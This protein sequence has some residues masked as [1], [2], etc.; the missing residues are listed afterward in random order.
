M[1][2][3]SSSASPQREACTSRVRS[4][5]VASAAPT[6]HTRRSGAGTSTSCAATRDAGILRVGRYAPARLARF[7]H[8]AGG[9]A[10]AVRTDPCAPE[11]N[12]EEATMSETDSRAC[13]RRHPGDVDRSGD[14]ELP[15]RAR[16]RDPCSPSWCEWPPTPRTHETR[17]HGSSSW[18]TTRRSAAAIGQLLEPRAAEVDAA[19]DRLRGGGRSSGC[20]APLPGLLIRSLGRAPAIVFVCGRPTDYGPEFPAHDMVLSATYTAA[21]NLL[22]A[23]AGP[24]AGSCVHHAAPPRRAADPRAARP[25]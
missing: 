11:A 20:T 23:A 8:P 12:L 6:T 13:H 19:A 2:R 21:Q 1:P 10:V 24:R 7:Q 3:T 16:V 15:R 25:R 5:R 4:T 9:A 18:S 22:L 17:N 14:P